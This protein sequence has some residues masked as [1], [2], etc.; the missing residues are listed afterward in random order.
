METSYY[1]GNV[2][3]VRLD[4]LPKIKHS[5]VGFFITSDACFYAVFF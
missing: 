4:F 5:P 1:F 2:S 3:L